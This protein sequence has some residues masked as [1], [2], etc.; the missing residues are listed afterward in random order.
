VIG[1]LIEA[2]DQVLITNIFDFSALHAGQIM[3]PRTR[4]DAVPVTI[5]LSELMET[6][7]TSAHTRLP[8]Y[9]NDLDHILGLVHLKDLLHY[10]LEQEADFDLRTLMNPIPF[11]PEVLQADRLLTL[12]KKERIHMAV[13]L[14]EYGG[15]AGLITLED[16]IEEVVGDVHDEFDT[17]EEPA[18]AV[19]GPGHIVVAG[20]TRLD[21]IED[22]VVL[23][24]D[25]DEIETVAGVLMTEIELPPVV[26][27]EVSVKNATLRI[28]AVSGLTIEKVSIQYDAGPDEDV[29]TEVD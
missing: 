12:L 1:G 17:D 18:I 19:I 23:E 9:E 7:F 22:F 10:H 8:V 25:L 15:T 24:T 11:I 27:A 6:M 14:D 5:S 28:E 16:L 3:T 20:E 2:E 26:G 4:I 29:E 21:E 13:V